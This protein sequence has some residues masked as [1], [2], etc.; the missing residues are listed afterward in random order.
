M[1][2]T[3]IGWCKAIIISNPT[4]VSWLEIVLRKGGG[5]TIYFWFFFHFIISFHYANKMLVFTKII[6]SLHQIRIENNK[7][8]REELTKSVG[9]YN[10]N[11]WV[12]FLCPILVIL[13]WIICGLQ[14]DHIDL[15]I[16][17]PLQ[18]IVY[19][20]HSHNYNELVLGQLGIGI[21]SEW[22]T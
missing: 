7:N 18:Y 22:D 4:I 8:P 2:L 21:C 20:R 16:D 1:P 13:S 3:K 15:T 10:K 6:H 12:V 9:E 11:L 14:E 19:G 17:R 5:L